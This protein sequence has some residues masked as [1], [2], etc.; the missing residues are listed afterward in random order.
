MIPCNIKSISINA[1]YKIA[2]KWSWKSSRTFMY[3]SKEA[4]NFKKEYTEFLEMSNVKEMFNY[5]D[6]TKKDLCLCLNKKIGV[7]N[8]GSDVD[9]S[10]KLLQ[11]VL[12]DYFWFNDNKIYKQIS[13]KRKVEKGKEYVD[14]ELYEYVQTEYKRQV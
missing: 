6:F 10:N 7:S 3:L 14:F 2:K 9:N 4:N 13:E 1:T 8:I 11:D 5:I 12:A